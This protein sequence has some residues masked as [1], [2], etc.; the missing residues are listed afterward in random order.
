[1]IEREAIKK[2]TDDFVRKVQ[3]SEKRY[4]IMNE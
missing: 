4:E 3:N 1:M 2:Q